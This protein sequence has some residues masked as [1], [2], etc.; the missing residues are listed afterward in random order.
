MN[1][2]SARKTSSSRDQGDSMMEIDAPA[3]G[4]D[5]PATAAATSA[6]VEHDATGRDMPAN[7]TGMNA[8]VQHDA[9][10]S[11]LTFEK[12]QIDVSSSLRTAFLAAAHE[13]TALAA[14]GNATPKGQYKKCSDRLCL[15]LRK[16]IVCRGPTELE[17]SHAQSSRPS[18]S[19]ESRARSSRQMAVDYTQLPHAVA[20]M[21]VQIPCKYTACMQGTVTASCNSTS[22]ITCNMDANSEETYQYVYGLSDAAMHLHAPSQGSSV[23]LVYDIVIYTSSKCEPDF[24][25]SL[26]R[27]RKNVEQS[28]AAHV[29]LAE[30]VK[31]WEQDDSCQMLAVM[32]QRNSN[33]NNIQ[34]VISG[35]KFCLARD[36]EIVGALMGCQEL[37][38]GFAGECVCIHTCVYISL[39]CL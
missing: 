1:D 36:K 11:F 37:E 29:K 27:N 25:E 18:K 10:G 26:F 17:E 39:Q 14:M 12:E 33:V 8:S 32:L 13:A 3:T 28:S 34:E 23:F 6:T 16:M 2:E 9:T 22:P 4:I 30:C 38:V 7:A 24:V 21:I 20:R 35:K 15:R 19:D 31:H 5:V